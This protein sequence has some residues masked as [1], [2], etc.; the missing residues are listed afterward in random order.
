MTLFSQAVNMNMFCMVTVLIVILLILIQKYIIDI[1]FGPC[2]LTI[3]FKQP[4]PLVTD[5]TCSITAPSRMTGVTFTA[6][7]AHSLYYCR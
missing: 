2:K 1:N 4:A 5:F 6:F 3:K 7:T